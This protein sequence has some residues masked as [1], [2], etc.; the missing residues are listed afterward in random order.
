MQRSCRNSS[1][2]CQILEA[3][4]QV[5]CL[6][7][8]ALKSIQILIGC[9]DFSL[10]L[11]LSFSFYFVFFIVLDLYFFFLFTLAQIK[12]K[13][14]YQK[15]RKISATDQNLYGFQCTKLLVITTAILL[16][17][18]NNSMSN[19]GNFVALCPFRALLPQGSKHTPLACMHRRGISAAK[20][21]DS[22][23]ELLN[24]RSKFLWSCA[25]KFVH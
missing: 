10:S 23:I 12:R 19:S 5:L 22:V 6:K 24:F 17:K 9:A 2:N 21:L 7:I 14:K 15:E 1:Q 18:S 20:L 4:F 11:V 13:K 8:C 3:N 16:L 25:Q